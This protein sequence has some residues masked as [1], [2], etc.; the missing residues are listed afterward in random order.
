MSQIRNLRDFPPLG[1][2]ESVKAVLKSSFDASKHESNSSK[3]KK[4]NVDGYQLDF[5]KFFSTSSM[6][7]S[8][9]WLHLWNVPL[10][11]FTRKGLSYI[12]NAIG[13][14]LYMDNTTAERKKLVYAKVC[15]EI[16]VARKIPQDIKVVLDKTCPNRKVLIMFKYRDLSNKGLKLMLLVL[17]MREQVQAVVRIL[18]VKQAQV[19]DSMRTLEVDK[20]KGVL[21]I[22]VNDD[23]S[24]DVVAKDV[25]VHDV[26]CSIQ[27]QITSGNKDA[28][29]EE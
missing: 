1:S 21:A 13:N 26:E 22:N 29:L 9:V 2:V 11:L 7:K 15:V 8:S 25:E 5:Q 18:R 17:W 12:A 24:K 28:N 6:N 20:G 3:D 4:V 27:R 16:D 14:P 23:D 19:N 10:E